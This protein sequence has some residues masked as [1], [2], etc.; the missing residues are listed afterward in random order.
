MDKGQL[1]RLKVVEDQILDAV[2]EIAELI[3]YEDTQYIGHRNEFGDKQLKIDVLSDEIIFMNLKASK[4][5]KYALSEEK[6]ELHDMGG[7]GFNV[8]FDPLDGS[9]IIDVNWAV[10]TIFAIWPGDN[11]LIGQ[12]PRSIVS[13]GI[14]VYGPRT[15]VVKYNAENGFVEELTLKKDA[16]GK[17]FW[18]KTKDK[19][20]IA[21]K[22]KIFAPANLRATSDNRNYEELFEYWRK[23]KY[24]LRYSGGLV[25]DIY[26]IFVR[27]NG[28]FSNPTS[29]SAPAK[30]R[31]LYEVAPCAFLMEKAGGKST[32]GQESIM[33]IKT[34]SYVQRSAL[35]LG[36]EE[37]VR[38]FE[39]IM[40]A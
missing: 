17:T 28:V 11:N 30:L 24:T 18:S 25:P 4:L 10:G 26:Q 33:D 2:A 7:E 3:A 20:H 32:N 34:E 36:S 35:C 12:T 40:N 8:T 9:S 21:E 29:E 1:T 27:G 15:T 38:R 31:F 37:E 39:K 13:A 14:A 5:V 19:I 16:E 22:T 6:P 23:S